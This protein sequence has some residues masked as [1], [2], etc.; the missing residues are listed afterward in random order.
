MPSLSSYAKILETQ[1]KT[2]G[3]VRKNQ[4]DM[5]MEATWDRD[6]QSRVAYFYDYF[7]DS[8]PLKLRNLN[9][10]NDPLKTPIDIKYIVSSSQTYDKD[11]I[12]YHIQFKPSYECNIKYYKEFFEDKY[13]GIFPCGLYVDIPDNEENYNRWLVVNKANYYDPQFSTFDILPC[14]YVFQWI[15]E[16]H[17]HQMAGV[18]RSQNS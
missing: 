15:H 14:D 4:S 9:S 8:E 6:I 5:I 11:Q 1:G 3:Q 17:K 2:E 10:P 13:H 18:L 7:H 16:G 12:T